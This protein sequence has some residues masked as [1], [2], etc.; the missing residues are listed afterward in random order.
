MV[1]VTFFGKTINFFLLVKSVVL[2]TEKVSV[3]N[4]VV[5]LGSSNVFF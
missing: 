2:L 3:V 1:K 4:T 5:I